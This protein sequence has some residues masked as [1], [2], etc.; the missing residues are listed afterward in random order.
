MTDEA[1]GSAQ[2]GPGAAAGGAAVV[3]A[4]P[5]VL[6]AGGAIARAVA[7]IEIGWR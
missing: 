1:V 3:E 5:R 2:D 4:V 7:D 6:G